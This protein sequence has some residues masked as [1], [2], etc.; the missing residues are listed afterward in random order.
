MHRHEENAIVDKHLI[1]QHA[2]WSMQAYAHEIAQCLAVT[3][4]QPSSAAAALLRKWTCEQSTLRVFLAMS[5][6]KK[7]LS[8]TSIRLDG[9]HGPTAPQLS[10]AWYL[11]LLVSIFAA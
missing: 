5:S 10:D 4:Q 2:R 9:T 11:E 3:D 1:A 8:F 6:L 7:Y